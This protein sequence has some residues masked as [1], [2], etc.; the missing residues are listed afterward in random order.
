MIPAAIELQGD[1]ISVYMTIILKKTVDI[2]NIICYNF[3]IDK[4][5]MWG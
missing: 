4:P 5:M 3:F 1:T 2:L